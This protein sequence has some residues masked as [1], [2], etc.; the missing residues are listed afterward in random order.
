MMKAIQHPRLFEGLSEV[1][2]KYFIIAKLL[3]SKKELP[4]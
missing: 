2:K 3:I 1:K 4:N